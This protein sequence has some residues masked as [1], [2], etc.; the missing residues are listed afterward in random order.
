[1]GVTRA[2]MDRRIDEHFGF[3]A[4]LDFGAFGWAVVM[5]LSA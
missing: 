5:R 3:E 2:E 1:M 4:Q